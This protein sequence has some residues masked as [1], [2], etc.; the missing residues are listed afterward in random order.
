M[1]IENLQSYK[2]FTWQ[3]N[4]ILRSKTSKI[5]NF[6]DDIFELSQIMV[7]L[8]TNNDWIWLATPQ[9]WVF[10]Q[11]IVVWQFKKVWKKLKFKEFKFLINPEIFYFSEKKNIDSEWCLSLP[12][13][14]WKVERSSNIKVKYN[15][16]MWKEHIDEFNDLNARIVQHEFDHL[17]GILFI[18]KALEIESNKKLDILSWYKK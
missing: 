14:F 13:I 8:L 15:D 4:P 11:L 2:I 3:N 17:Q 18:D 1:N 12:W 10:R 16:L 7:N 5:T 9:I 6:N